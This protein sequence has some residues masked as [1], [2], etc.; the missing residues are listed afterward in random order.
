M[1][2]YRDLPTDTKR[3]HLVLAPRGTEHIPTERD[4]RV[5]TLLPASGPWP[6]PIPLTDKYEAVYA[7]RV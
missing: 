2:N 3:V 6:M 1:I 4:M 5:R 7:E